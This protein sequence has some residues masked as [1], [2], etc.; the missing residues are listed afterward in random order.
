M[1]DSQGRT[2]NYMRISIT[3]RCNL[4]CSYCMPDGIDTVDM[5]QILTY[6]EIVAICQEA[7]ALGINTIRITGGEPLVRKGAPALVGMIKAIPGIEKVY[8]TTNGSLIPEYMSELI[9]NGID[10]INISLDSTNR[11]TYK[12]ITGRDLYASVMEGIQMVMKSKV[13]LKLN[14]VIMDNDNYK[15]MLLFAR[16]NPVCVRFIELMPLGVARKMEGTD[17]QEILSYI[18]KNYPGREWDNSPYGNGPAR[19]LTI[20][21]FEGKVGFISPI[22][23][24]FC[25]QCNRIRLTSTG[26]IKPCLCYGTSFDVKTPLRAGDMKEV[27]NRLIYSIQKKPCAHCFDRP[28]E[29]S[30]QKKMV[31]IGG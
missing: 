21:G 1:K 27:R 15:D 9:E 6:E 2:I 29:V 4:R 23:E 18:D 17:Y 3:D 31:S 10:G 11:D 22:H 12:K 13:K 8:M 14:T 19:Y 26:E 7:S 20:P 16:D 28:E 24:N 5:D 25:N 30:E